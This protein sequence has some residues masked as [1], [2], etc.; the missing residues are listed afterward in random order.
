MR[1]R[2]D[3]NSNLF[4]L[5]KKISQ[6]IL[7]TRRIIEEKKETREEEEIQSMHIYLYIYRFSNLPI[8]LHKIVMYLIDLSIDRLEE[9][10]ISLLLLSVFLLSDSTLFFFLEANSS[11]CRSI[12]YAEER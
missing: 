5:N 1:I 3:R 9:S 8:N 10:K 4:R 7:F 6:L 12:S 2:L 11:S